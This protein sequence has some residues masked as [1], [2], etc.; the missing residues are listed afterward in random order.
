[1]R[2]IKL[3][4]LG[5]SWFNVVQEWI[6]SYFADKRYSKVTKM[7]KEIEQDILQKCRLQI[8]E[9][10]GWGGADQWHNEVFTELSERIQEETDVMLSSTTL[11]RVWGRVNY[12]GR[13]SISTLNALSR[14]LGYANWRDFKNQTNIEAPAKKET[15]AK[16][17]HG[18]LLAMASLLAI[19]F[20]SLFSIID[21]GNSQAIAPDYSSIK[22][23]SYP[24]TQGLPNSVVFDLNLEEVKSDHIL[25]QQY[26]DATKTI[27]INAQ[28]RQ[29]TGIYYYPGYFR[30]KLLIDQ[31]IVKE[32]DLLSKPMIGSLRLITN[33][34]P[35]ILLL[36]NL[37]L[38]AFPFHQKS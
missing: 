36:Y 18:L 6:F 27:E 7:K 15:P 35:N 26:W 23:S 29:A 2:G 34:F 5:S 20:V 21:L 8:E 13:P 3:D 31:Q 30:A 11:K 25:I 24:I 19:L 28:Q 1:L 12:K 10:L 32:H 33:R 38:P 4:Q 37:L 14:F 22:F 17:N 9:K 16:S